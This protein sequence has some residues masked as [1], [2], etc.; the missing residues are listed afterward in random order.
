MRKPASRTFMSTFM[1]GQST[2]PSYA[3]ETAYPYY[4]LRVQKLAQSSP[5]T[6][7]SAA[8]D[9]VST[10]FHLPLTFDLHELLA[11]K[12]LQTYLANHPLYTLLNI[13]SKG[14]LTAWN[15]WRTENTGLLEELGESSQKSL[16]LL[17]KIADRQ[18]MCCW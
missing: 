2:D 5:D 17:G 15:A 13:F 10:A 18:M 9:L 11:L 1:T 3:S 16:S 7:K 14:D 8:V 12:E 6:A 4:L